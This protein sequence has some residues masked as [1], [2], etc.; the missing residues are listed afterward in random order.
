MATLEEVLEQVRVAQ[1][2]RDAAHAL[3]QDKMNATQIAR[4]EEV[5]ACS[6]LQHAEADLAT[7]ITTLLVMKAQ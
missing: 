6:S 3:Y 7:A 1:E 5:E 2:T 4:Q